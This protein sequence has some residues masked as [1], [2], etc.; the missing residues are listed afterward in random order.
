LAVCRRFSN[1]VFFD[2]LDCT[3]WTFFHAI[4][5]GDAGILIYYGGIAA[6][7]VK[8]ALLAYVNADPTGGALVSIDDRTWHG[9]SFP[10]FYKSHPLA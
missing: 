5:A 4:A 2:V 7:Y 3:H 6:Y 1:S 9:L 10:Q 8:R